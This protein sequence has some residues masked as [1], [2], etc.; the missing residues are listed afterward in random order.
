V[1]RITVFFIFV[2]LLAAPLCADSGEAEDGRKTLPAYT[3][4]LNTRFGM[5]WGQAEEQVYGSNDS[6]RLVSQLLWN[7]KPLWYAGM[8]L[9]FSQKD[10]LAGLGFFG[11]L[12]VKFGIPGR[13]GIMEDRDWLAAGGGLSHYSRHDSLNSGTLFLDLLAGLSVPLGRVLVFRFLLGPSYTHLSW[14]AY[15]GY[16]RYGKNVGTNFNPIYQ[17]LE[18][19]DPAIPISGAVI[20]YSQ[21]WFF[22]LFDFSLLLFPDRFFSGT[23][24]FNAGPV[25]KFAG[26]DDH[27]MRIN[28]GFYGQFADEIN[29]GYVLEPGGEFRFSPAEKLSLFMR[30]SW[31]RVIAASHGS[32]YGRRTGDGKWNWDS[33][34]NTSGGSFQTM[35]LGIG[36]EVRF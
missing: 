6:D 2:S 28:T 19:S 23:L 9:E 36:L 24:F 10:P 17:P 1:K 26:W 11:A 16:Y 30:F 12:S 13:S 5:F 27:Y 29:G 32:S 35:D 20:S 18:D 3:L 7:I 8:G 15:D 21:D 22:L 25:L 34:G 14:N 4:S 33:L 31:R